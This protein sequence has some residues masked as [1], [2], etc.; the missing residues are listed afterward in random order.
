MFKN[1]E[2]R[3]VDNKLKLKLLEWL[4]NDVRLLKLN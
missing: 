3:P 2:V 1:V 4:S